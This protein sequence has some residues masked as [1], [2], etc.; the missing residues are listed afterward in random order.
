MKDLLRET[1]K[2][3]NLPPTTP[4]EF[5]QRARTLQIAAGSPEIRNSTADIV[6][7]CNLNSLSL[8]ATVKLL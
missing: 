4:L 2:M 5:N 1:E 6:L 3:E 7:I 8:A